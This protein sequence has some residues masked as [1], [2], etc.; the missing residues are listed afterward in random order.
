MSKFWDLLERSIIVQSALP[1]MFG[2][3]ACVLWLRGLAIPEK[4]WQLT[5]MCVVF[6]MGTKVQHTIDKNRSNK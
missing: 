4:L 5:L 3:C 6:W 1:M 2:V